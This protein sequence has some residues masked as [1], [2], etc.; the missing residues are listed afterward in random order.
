MN[1]S[2]K[3]V[4]NYRMTQKTTCRYT[5][6]KAGISRDGRNTMFMVVLLTIIKSVHERT[7]G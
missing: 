2:K 7:N 1:I 4:Q 6:S 3:I 5:E